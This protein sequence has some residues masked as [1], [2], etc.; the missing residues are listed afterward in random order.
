VIARDDDA[1]DIEQLRVG[2]EFAP[3]CREH[4]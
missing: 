4:H 2:H 1:P 3:G